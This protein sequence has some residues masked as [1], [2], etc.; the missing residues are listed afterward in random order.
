MWVPFFLGATTI[1]TKRCFSIQL[2]LGGW[3]INSYIFWAVDLL[4]G[5][6]ADQEIKA[7][8]CWPQHAYWENLPR[9]G[10]SKE[11]QEAGKEGRE[12]QKKASKEWSRGLLANRKMLHVESA[13]II[14]RFASFKVTYRMTGQSA[15]IRTR[16]N[17]GSHLTQCPH[18]RK[19]RSREKRLVQSHVDN[20]RY[21]ADC[22][23]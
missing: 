4:F 19:L 16:K 12:V 20:G 9:E 17:P 23:T 11:R 3:Y 18:L 14:A 15:V 7:S 6:R 22:K 8:S 13:G 1:S 5:A 10:E 2:D 21:R